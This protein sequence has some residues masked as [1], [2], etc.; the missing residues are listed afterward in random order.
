MEEKENS[1]NTSEQTHIYN[2]LNPDEVRVNQSP[3]VE[4]ICA[5]LADIKNRSEVRKVDF[6]KTFKPIKNI[7]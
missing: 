3:N 2:Q 7:K 4:R 6:N 1:M 5:V